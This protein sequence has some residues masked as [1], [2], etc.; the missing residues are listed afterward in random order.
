MYC[1]ILQEVNVL[2][3][4]CSDKSLAM[5]SKQ[6]ADCDT[7]WPFLGISYAKHEEVVRNNFR[8]YENYKLSLLLEWRN[9]LGVQ[10]TY[11]KLSEAFEEWG[12]QDISADVLKKI[13][14]EGL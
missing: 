14:S 6:L 11:Q 8:M 5:I 12:N 13:S 1:D 2:E 10:A 3:Q 9:N 7:L 4:V